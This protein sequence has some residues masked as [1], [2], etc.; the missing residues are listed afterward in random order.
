[1]KP[2]A[3]EL[4]PT[5]YDFA[6]KG[7]VIVFDT[8]TTGLLDSDEVVQIAVVLM[9][10]G[11]VVIEDAQYLKNTVPLDGTEAAQVI[12]LT[13]AFISEHGKNPIEVLSAF[14]MLVGE[15]ISQRGNCLLVSHNLSF[16]YRMI[17]NMLKRYGL[18]EMPKEAVGCCTKEFVK[19]LELPKS[20]LPGNHLRNCIAAFGLD[21]ANTHDALDDARACLKLFQYLTAS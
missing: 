6:L 10:D 13:D 8:E 2:F 9:R 11:K 16:D 21:A 12:G 15:S 19:S 3:L 14:S 18:P 5:Y 7:D 4:I 20:V 17:S 1:M